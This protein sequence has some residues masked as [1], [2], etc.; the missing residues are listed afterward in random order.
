[1][2]RSNAKRFRGLL[3]GCLV[4]AALVAVGVGIKAAG[5]EKKEA[6]ASL[7]AEQVIA[8]ITTAVAAKPGNV[9]ELEAEREKGRTL[10]E[11]EILAQDGKT[12]EVS[13]DV[14]TNTVVEVEADE[15]DDD[16]DDDDEN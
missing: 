15:D 4:A 7:S 13:V 8:S 2:I 5:Q 6:K 3:F 14:A 9:L 1:M 16:D 12:Y 10:C 11:V